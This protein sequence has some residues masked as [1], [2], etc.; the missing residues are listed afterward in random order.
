[1]G[2]A[3][4]TILS[5]DLGTTA[6]KIG[7]F[8]VDGKL[9]CIESQEQK[10]ITPS[11]GRS[12]QDALKTWETIGELTS[13]IHPAHSLDTVSAIS[14]S[15]QRGSVVPLD[16]E[17]NP[18]T[19]LIVWMDRRGLPQKRWLENKIGLGAY[20]EISGH[21]ISH[22]T[23]ISK[24]LWLQRKAKEIWDQATV[25]A[26]P[27]TLFLHWLG[28]KDLVCDL[29]LGTYLFP[30]NIEKKEWSQKISNLTQFP[31]KKLPDLVSAT[32]VVGKLS[33]KAADHLGLKAGIPIVAGGGD[34]QCAAVG[35]GVVEPGLCMINIGTAAG[36]Q[37]YLQELKKDPEHIINT[38]AH[39]DPDA[40][41]MEGHTQAS[42]AV[43]RWFRDEF[44]LVEKEYSLRSSHDVFD[45]LIDETKHVPPG[46]EELI[47]LPT[48]NGSTAPVFNANLRGVLSGLTLSHTREHIIRAVLE[49]ISMEIRWLLN[50]ITES[51][52]SIDKIRLVGGGSKNTYWNQIHADFLGQGVETISVS[53]SALA[54][55]AMCG[56]V[57]IG[58]CENLQEAAQKFI[59][60]KQTVEPD[61]DRARLYD[62]VFE[63]YQE[64][65]MILNERY[66]ND[67]EN[68][69]N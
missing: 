67:E 8:S 2:S 61:T 42:G 68:D 11:P 27:Q 40:W 52:V 33:A 14:L 65:F 1:M 19:N 56:A 23:G 20:H 15:I 12:E 38:A 54:G 66:F 41:E 25:V 9:I 16:D 18:L 62:G 63:R 6:T 36:V 45:L 44:G 10:V 7:L 47:F 50:A 51:G 4:N 34:G 5:F 31:L 55:A 64:L 43:L 24:L 53:D 26:P 21:G 37:V 57:G 60:V 46:S 3:N 17:G 13:R 69:A 29:S 58:A 22:I 30:F 59:T 39:V 32:Q 48:F 28:C 35:S 49:G